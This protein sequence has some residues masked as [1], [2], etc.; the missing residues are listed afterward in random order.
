[1]RTPDAIE[2]ADKATD[3]TR[4]ALS[5]PDKVRALA[6]GDQETYTEAGALLQAIKALRREIDWTFDPIIK[7]AHEA[8][9]EALGQKR[10]AEAPL[11]EA[12]VLLK[13][14]IVAYDAKQ[15]EIRQVEER[16]LQEEARVAEERRRLDEAAALEREAARTGDRSLKAEAD[17]L[18][19]E[20][21]ATPTVVLASS[22]PKVPGIALRDN[23]KVAPTVDVKKLA[24]EIAA[25]R[26]PSTLLVPNFTALNGLARSLKG[27]LR[28]P[29][30]QVLNDRGVASR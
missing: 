16:R 13:R 5:W 29:G 17:A 24:A 7:K 11:A 14:G 6:I 20:P 26:Q 25:G 28:I 9:A 12:E 15:E 19:E 8:H 18:I 30:V 1:M 21:V 4:E 10:K 22:T 27:Q 3:V 23:W 2:T